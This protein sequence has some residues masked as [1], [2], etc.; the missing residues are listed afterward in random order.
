MLW[1]VYDLEHGGKMMGLDIADGLLDGVFLSVHGVGIMGGR[2]IVDEFSGPAVKTVIA[3][4]LRALQIRPGV[5]DSVFPESQTDDQIPD[6]R[7]QKKHA[8]G[9]TDISINTHAD[10]PFGLFFL[11]YHIPVFP[12]KG[13]LRRARRFPSEIGGGRGYAAVLKEL[14]ETC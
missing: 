9:Q 5:L 2:N 3:F 12:G 14:F 8:D 13:R 7:C 4:M 10:P 11:F 6:C 1:L